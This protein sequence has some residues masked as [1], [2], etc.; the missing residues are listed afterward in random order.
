MCR[1]NQERICV[2]KVA[3][4]SWAA[5]Y[6]A[7][8]DKS[9]CTAC[10]TSMIRPLHCYGAFRNSCTISIIRPFAQLPR[11]WQARCGEVGYAYDGH[12]TEHDHDTEPDHTMYTSNTLNIDNSLDDGTGRTLLA[13]TGI[14]ESFPKSQK[15]YGRKVQKLNKHRMNSLGE[16]IQIYLFIAF[17]CQRGTCPHTNALYRPAIHHLEQT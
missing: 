14:S 16:D 5:R 15:S 13:R 3:R 8:V 1:R 9:T 2:V 17:S 4:C 7:A 6:G 11:C 12:D 10:T